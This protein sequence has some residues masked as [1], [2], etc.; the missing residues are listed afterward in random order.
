MYSL[1]IYASTGC[2]QFFKEISRDSTSVSRKPR[3]SKCIVWFFV[4]R[5]KTHRLGGDG[6]YFFFFHWLWPSSGLSVEM[7]GQPGSRYYP[8]DR[9]VHYA[10]RNEA[11]VTVY[12]SSCLMWS[13]LTTRLCTEHESPAD[14]TL[15]RGVFD[16]SF[17]PF[18]PI[19]WG[20]IDNFGINDKD[21]IFVEISIILKSL[22]FWIIV[23]IDL[24]VR[25]LE[26]LGNFDISSN[27]FF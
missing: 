9:N 15:C 27:H 23:R 10:R 19:F 7:A 17:T 3:S 6:E 20:I 22:K 1:W 12:T 18:S 24:N 25:Y 8:V 4:N 21:G 11:V 14:A 2:T 26:T 5:W 13:T 16:S